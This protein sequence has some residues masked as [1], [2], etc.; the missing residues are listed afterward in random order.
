[1]SVSSFSER[2]YICVCDDCDKREIVRE[3]YPRIYNG[4]QAVRS[5][6]WSFGKDKSVKCNKCRRSN[7]FYDK[8][9]YIRT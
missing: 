6:G 2:I 9:K 7:S 8:Y 1:M 3:N 5:L 4:A